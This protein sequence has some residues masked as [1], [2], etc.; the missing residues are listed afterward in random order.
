[1][2]LNQEAVDYFHENKEFTY[3]DS[4][5]KRVKGL[6]KEHDISQIKLAELLGKSNGAIGH[7]E[8]GRRD[9]S[10]ETLIQMCKIFN[11]SLDYLFGLSNIRRYE[12]SHKY[13]QREMYKVGILKD[14]NIDKKAVDDFVKKFDLVKQIASGG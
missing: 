2:G 3:S 7:W 6:R 1:M 4:F 14:G 9:P 11:C 10:L 8:T 12:E 5:V 13:M